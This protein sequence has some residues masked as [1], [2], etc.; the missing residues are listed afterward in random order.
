MRIKIILLSMALHLELEIGEF[1]IHYY[2]EF[3]G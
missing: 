3:S 1:S 2:A